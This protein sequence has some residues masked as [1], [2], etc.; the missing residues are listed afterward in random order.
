MQGQ[1]KMNEKYRH[2]YKFIIDERGIMYCK[3]MLKGI[4]KLD[5]H[6]DLNGMYGIRSVYFDTYD[7]TFF[8]ENESGL[9]VRHKWRIRT[10]S[11]SELFFLE[12]KSKKNGMCSKK[13]IKLSEEEVKRLLNK[14]YELLNSDKALLRE[15]CLEG[16]RTLLRPVVIIE[17]ERIPFIY[18]LGNVRITLDMNISASRQIDKFF[19][20]AIRKQPIMEVG[21]H[22]LEIKYDEFLPVELEKILCF[23]NFTRTSFS[24]DYLGSRFVN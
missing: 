7:D 6:T 3:E 4:C 10:Y 2:E 16:K 1:A 24:K 12:R 15:F 14:D 13:T 8:Y 20:E 21:E 19:D 17:Y 22:V 9:D 18:K 11:N 5:L 23:G